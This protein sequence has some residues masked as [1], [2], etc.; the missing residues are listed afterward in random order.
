L[1]IH[2]RQGVGD[3]E[4]AVLET[5]F[6]YNLRFPGQ[7]YDVEKAS[8]YNYFRDYD[9]TLG[10]YVES[11]PIGLRGGLN[12]F[13]YV[14]DD[15]LAQFDRLGLCQGSWQLMGV[16]FDQV[17][18]MPTLTCTCYWVCAP[19]RGTVA[20]SGNTSHLPSS[21]GVPFFNPNKFRSAGSGG[22]SSGA[23]GKGGTPKP[24][25]GGGDIG[26]GNDCLCE[27]PGP[28]T[29]CPSCYADG[30]VGQASRRRP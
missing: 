29:G 13:A 22:L 11:D 27:V 8:N 4:A 1:A 30:T 21:R 12:T 26:S 24:G 20:W 19:C 17:P 23:P 9:P 5:H 18:M 3:L 6:N 16:N 28:E 10:R 25:K 15:P 14:S 2:G 7:Y